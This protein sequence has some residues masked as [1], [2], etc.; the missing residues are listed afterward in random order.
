MPDYIV[1]FLPMLIFVGLAFKVVGFMIRDEL[2]LRFLVA[3]GMVCDLLFYLLLPEPILQSVLTNA[4]MASINVALITVIIFE[5]TTLR[6]SPEARELYHAAFQPL[7][8]GHFRQIYRRV[9]WREAGSDQILTRDGAP[10]TELCYVFADSYTIRK[11]GQPFT[12]RGPAFVGEV[13]LLTG[14][15]SSATVELEAGTRYAAI[16]FS[17]L[18]RSMKRSS[19]FHNAIVALFAKDLAEKTA[20]SAPIARRS[21]SGASPSET[22]AE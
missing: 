2:R 16:P 11:D 22:A 21:G 1:E 8:P 10:V 18:K 20:N 17:T 5:R 19:A 14:N 3:I 15:M 9:E 7:T 12:A 6:M 4:V 13:A